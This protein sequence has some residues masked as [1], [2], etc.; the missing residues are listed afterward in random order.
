MRATETNGH[1]P[2][3]QRSF[4]HPNPSEDGGS[5][6]GALIDQG[7]HYAGL[8][9]V[10]SPYREGGWVHAA[11]KAVGAAVRQCPVRFY[12]EDPRLNSKATAVDD[13]HPLHKLFRRPNPYM[14]GAKFFESG[15]YHRKLDGEDVWF[16]FDKQRN[17]VPLT[18]GA[19]G[20]FIDYPDFILPV[21]GQNVELKTDG[22]GFPALWVYNTGKGAGIQMRPHQALQFSD[23]D[24]DNP[25]RGLGDVEVLM[26][27]LGLEAG[28]Y[29]YLQAMLLHSGDP[30]GVITTENEMSSEEEERAANEARDKFSLPNAGRWH[31]VSGKDVKYVPH[32]FGPK[33]MQFQEMLGWVLDRTAAILGVPKE[34]L[35]KLEEAS[36]SNFQ[37]AVRQFWQGGNGVLAYMASV[38]DVLNNLFLPHLKDRQARTFVARFD[39]S[40]IEALRD[41]RVEKLDAALKLAQGNA[42]LSFDEAALMVGLDPDHTQSEWGKVAWLPPNITTAEAAKENADNPPDPNMGQDNPPNPDND[43]GDETPF[44][45]SSDGDTEGEDGARAAPSA[46][47]RGDAANATPSGSPSNT[48]AQ[49]ARRDYFAAYEERVLVRGERTVKEAALGY[50]RRYELAQKK[51]LEDFASKTAEPQTKTDGE[52]N[53]LSTSDI[54]ADPNYLLILLLDHPEWV[55]KLA[56]QMEVPIAEVLELA[57]LD[58]TDEIG[59]V[60]LTRNDPWAMDFLRGQRFKLAEGV[61]STLAKEVKAAFVEVFKEAPFDVATLQEHIRRKL[62]EL[63]GALRKAFRNRASRASAIARTETG[64]ASNGARLQQMDREGVEQHQWVTSGDVFVRTK[65]PKTHDHVVLDGVVKDLGDSF[66]ENSTLRHPHDPEG[67]AGDVINCRCV[68]APVVKD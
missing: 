24:P 1:P 12:R 43:T 59:G 45:G 32:K 2:K 10:E 29:R 27:D 54:V 56:A 5:W 61:N 46:R 34:V 17:P 3:I 58:L 41:D 62:P 9:R 7:A 14:T 33:D 6:L 66:R 35:G 60:A 36:F 28:S 4:E 16:M 22:V 53:P 13:N 19:D 47:I 68:T 64:R 44:P 37:T 8:E 15:V 38:E 42:G 23:Y 55:T 48:L 52:G 51:R 49:K 25:L 57:A 31:V 63:R 20:P 67:Q 65:P 50:L 11:M 40:S 30:G 39:L 21:R 26:Q 18:E